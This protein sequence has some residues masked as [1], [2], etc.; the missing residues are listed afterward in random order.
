VNIFLLTHSPSPYQVEF[1]NEIALQ[2]EVCLS[3]AYLFSGDLERRWSP[4]EIRHEALMVDG[5][6]EK[7]AMIAEQVKRADLAVFNYYNDSIATLL[8]DRRAD[9]DRP[10]VFWGERPGF[11]SASWVGQLVRRWKLRRLHATNAPI[12]GIGGFAIEGYRREF[13]ASRAYCDVPYFSNL[14]RFKSLQPR[15]SNGD[16][17]TILYCGTLVLRKG[18]DLL[19]E[20]FTTVAREFRHLRLQIVGDGELRGKLHQRL[21]VLD[22]RVEFMGFK[23]WQQLPAVYHCADVLC[24][25]SR[26]DGWGLVVPEGLAAGLPVIGTDRMGAALEFLETGRNGWL[27]RAGDRRALEAALREAAA[28]PA[29]R[30]AEMSEAARDSVK[31]HTLGHGVERF[32]A[33][34]RRA[35]ANW[36]S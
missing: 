1:F 25:P 27:V 24:V 19:A 4:A 9:A 14:D 26:Y 16:K 36:G 3:V 2:G 8:I 30:L 10:W 6:P 17:R 32:I 23:D 34:A 13:G 5:V 11:R 18:V 20:A 33:A 7:L 31:K 12:W 35:V 29:E 22:G 21:H 28:L 15:E